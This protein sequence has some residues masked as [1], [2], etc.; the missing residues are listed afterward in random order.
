[1]SY[2]LEVAALLH[3]I[4]KIINRSKNQNKPHNEVGADFLLNYKNNFTDTII[5][6]IKNHHNPDPN[7]PINDLSWILILADSF[8]AGKTRRSRSIE[9]DFNDKK[10]L[11]SLGSIFNLIQKDVEK[12]KNIKPKFFDVPKNK[13]QSINFPKESNLFVEQSSYQNILEELK[14]HLSNPDL[15]KNKSINPLLSVV[16][17]QLKYFPSST[18]LESDYDISLADHCRITAAFASCIEQYFLS[19]NYKDFKKFVKDGLPTKEAETEKLFLLCSFDVSGIQKFIYST[20]TES[21]LKQLRSKSLY[22]ELLCE[23]LADGIVESLGLSRCNIIYVGGGH[24]YILVPNTDKAKKA[25]R[26]QVGFTNDFLLKQFDIQLFVGSGSTPCSAL[27]LGYDYKDGD[28][29]FSK[30][31]SNLSLSV[32]KNKT[33][34]FN[35][36][37]FLRLNKSFDEQNTRECKHCGRPTKNTICEMCSSFINISSDFIKQNSDY[38]ILKEKPKEGTSLMIPYIE[39][40]GYLVVKKR[41][42]MDEYIKEFDKN[43]LRIYIKNNLNVS[44]Y[45]NGVNIF[46]GDYT[47]RNK[48]GDIDT[49]EGIVNNREGINR[50]AVLRL[51]VDNLGNTFKNGFN[52][53]DNNLTRMA[54]L[55]SELVIFFKY[56]IN[57]FLS[58]GVYHKN[59]FGNDLGKE[60]NISIIYSGGDDLFTIGTLSDT[61]DFS[62]DLFDAFNE[63]TNGKLTFSGGVGLFGT[64][65][66]ILQ[67]ALYTSDLESAAKSNADKNSVSLFEVNN[68]VKWSDLKGDIF[69][70][71]SKLGKYF[72]KNDEKGNSF[73][74]DIFLLLSNISKDTLHKLAYKLGREQANYRDYQLQNFKEL[75]DLI[76]E[77]GQNENVR[78][79][80]LIAIQLYVYENRDKEVSNGK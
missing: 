37:L 8:S 64:K 42:Q 44:F 25:F 77:A 5:N 30:T 59:K 79:K 62:L 72:K 39:K 46:I 71:Y 57:D 58:K 54:A 3:D 2:E 6:A 45:K 1:M 63:Y 52:Q 66:P 65:Y 38:I 19:N 24:C 23:N 43:I 15:F 67:T 14:I 10:S 26:D 21:A 31:M 70:Y 16:N 28:N 68:V 78:K 60:K 17:S 36:D 4:G 51:D 40:I 29:Y 80:L 41:E 13:F 7:L 18:Y 73:L 76:M 20:T 9:A 48:Y 61:I 69:D 47:V 22:L 50:I 55:S 56:Y 32:S 74:Y 34:R 11:H 49:I 35:K 75:I 27:D 33:H 12:N 53:K